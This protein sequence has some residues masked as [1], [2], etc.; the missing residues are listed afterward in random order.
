MSIVTSKT[1]LFPPA[2]MPT[3]EELNA[4]INE[5]VR[6]INENVC[7]QVIPEEDL[8]ADVYGVWARMLGGGKL[9]L[10]S[11]SEDDDLSDYD[12]GVQV[13]RERCVA[14]CMA[15]VEEFGELTRTAEVARMLAAR[16]EAE[17]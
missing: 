5:A 8:D 6:L 13:E 12:Y 10:P 11:E 14:L 1:Y 9:S 15:M 16:I 7:T 17:E 4:S 2:Q 3:N